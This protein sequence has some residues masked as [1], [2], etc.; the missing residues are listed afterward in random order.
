VMGPL[1]AAVTAG[2]VWV[3]PVLLLAGARLPLTVVQ[4]HG[5][6]SAAGVLLAATAVLL[7]R[8]D[9]LELGWMR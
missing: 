5:Q 2:T 6:A 8:H 9:R 4:W 1:A 3:L 7:L